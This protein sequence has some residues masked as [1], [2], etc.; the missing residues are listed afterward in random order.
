MT[1]EELKERIKEAADIVEVASKYTTLKRT[2]RYYR[3][4]CPFHQE[5]TPSFYVDPE[6]KLYHCFGCGAGGDVIKLVMEMEGVS[7]MEALK[8]LASQFG[9]P[10]QWGG[11][12]GSREDV[13]YRVLEDALSLYEQEFWKKGRGFSYARKRGIPEEVAK[14]LRLGYA[15]QGWDFILRALGEKYSP[16]TLEKAGLLIKKEGGGYYDRFRDRLMFPIFTEYGR[17]VGFGGRA[18]SSEEEAKYINSPETPVYKKGRVLYGLNWTKQEL[19]R[20]GRAIL[21]EGY[22]DF[23]ALY[24]KGVKNVVASLGTSLTRDQAFLLSRFTSE[25]VVNYDSDEAGMRASA[26]AVP[27]LFSAGLRVRVAKLTGAKDPDEF[28]EKFGPASYIYKLEEA[29]KGVIFLYEHYSKER[30]EVGVKIALE[31]IGNIPDPIARRYEVGEL[32]HVSGIEEEILISMLEGQPSGLDDYRANGLTPTE[33]EALSFLLE[34]PREFLSLFS[35]RERE[36]IGQ[37]RLS[38][39]L[40]AAETL[41]EGREVE[42]EELKKM[43]SRLAFEGRKTGVSP[44]QVR[45]NLLK[46]SVALLLKK[47]QR[48]IKEAEREGNAERIIELLKKKQ[49]LIKMRG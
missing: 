36:V 39:L 38:Y 10:F 22:M 32:S 16:E 17:V 18:I 23:L 21:V 47:L 5:K 28:M 31:A 14:T 30:R 25:V 19:R 27:I 42:D 7:F 33:E 29:E 37:T 8:S 46:Y 11:S 34:N 4:L 35:F 41:A 44:G 6:K 49:E 24:A 13:L 20:K 1:L 15:P 3:G 9:V 26:R 48:M 2:G 12:R 43:L 40:Q 45:E